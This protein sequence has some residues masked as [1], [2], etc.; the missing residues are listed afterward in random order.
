MP[1]NLDQKTRLRIALR[2]LSPE[3]DADDF[4]EFVSAFC[5]MGPPVT[6]E[7]APAL[8]IANAFDLE[9]KSVRDWAIGVSTP[10]PKLRRAVTAFL[11]K[12]SV[13]LGVTERS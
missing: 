13:Q 6:L 2:D 4:A 9:R 3:D 7:G 10:T 5:A 8:A 1:E 11:R 12:A